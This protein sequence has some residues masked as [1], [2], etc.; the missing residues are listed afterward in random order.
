MSKAELYRWKKEIEKFSDYFE[1]KGIFTKGIFKKL[2]TCMGDSGFVS[3]LETGDGF[4]MLDILMNEDRKIESNNWRG[5]NEVRNLRQLHPQL[6]ENKCW[7][8]LYPKLRSV[9]QKGTGEGEILLA[10]I[11]KDVRKAKDQDINAS[12]NHI[13]AKIATGC[14]KAHG[15]EHQAFRVTNNAAEACG[16][17]CDDKL[18][19]RLFCEEELDTIVQYLEMVYFRWPSDRILRV[20]K[21]IQESSEQ[22]GKQYLGTEVLLDYKEVDGFDL[23]MHIAAAAR[24]DRILIIGNFDDKEYI[25][26]HLKFSCPL[27]GNNTQA[28]ADGYVNAKL[29]KAIK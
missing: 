9:S 28:L 20:A 11:L 19:Q 17:V 1:E 5:A 23:Y 13:E 29:A 22:E 27:R 14:L 16:W 21:Y 24:D 6:A 10:L 8:N 15:K 4:E 7:Q 12:N 2:L 25:S 26:K 3:H 18:S